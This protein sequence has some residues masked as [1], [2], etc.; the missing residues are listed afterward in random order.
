MK[1][2]VSGSGRKQIWMQKKKPIWIWERT[3]IKA[4]VAA[5]KNPEEMAAKIKSEVEAQESKYGSGSKRRWKWKKS[6]NG[7]G[8]RS[9]GNGNRIKK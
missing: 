5:E 9:G 3:R 4:E 7:C 2:C 1:E 6:K 8:N